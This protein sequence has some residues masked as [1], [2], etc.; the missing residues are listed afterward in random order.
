VVIDN[1]TNWGNKH[2][3]KLVQNYTRAPFFRNHAPLFERLYAQKWEHLEELNR[4]LIIHLLKELSIDTRIE[5]G[6]DLG[7]HGKKTDFL[8]NL[9]LKVGA[10][11]YLSGP[12][13]RGYLEEQKIID[14][15]IRLIYQEYQPIAYRQCFEPFIPD[16]SAIDMIFNL[17][18]DRSREIILNSS[19]GLKLN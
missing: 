1:K 11:A 12:G 13:G 2:W 4:T 7:V 6:S 8:V 9:C 17:G 15:G 5:L 14:N 10:D 3:H 18:S 19:K 16:M